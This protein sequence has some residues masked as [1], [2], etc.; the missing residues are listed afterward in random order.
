MSPEVRPATSAERPA[1]GLV[2]ALVALTPFAVVPFVSA[3]G[4]TSGGDPAE[5]RRNVR[6]PEAF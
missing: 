2:Y 3:R 6:V 4:Q 5:K 1:R